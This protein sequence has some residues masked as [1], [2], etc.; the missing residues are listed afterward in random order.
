[1]VMYQN[2]VAPAMATGWHAL[3]Q[4][5]SWGAIIAMFLYN[6]FLCDPDGLMVFLMY[7]CIMYLIYLMFPEK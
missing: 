7:T 6:I 2:V 1:M 4:N 5:F 3:L